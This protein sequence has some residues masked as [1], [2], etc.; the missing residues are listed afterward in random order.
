MLLR[1]FNEDVEL[2]NHH[3]N[4]NG[5]GRKDVAG[6]DGQASKGSIPAQEDAEETQRRIQNAPDEGDE[7]AL[8]A[9]EDDGGVPVGAHSPL[10]PEFEQLDA[11]GA[12]QT[13][14]AE[15]DHERALEAELFEDEDKKVRD[16]MPE[17]EGEGD[18]VNTT[19]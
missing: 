19:V 3:D 11:L 8:P 12:E 18:E 4:R 16:A 14:L 13:A 10:N 15:E 2:V 9:S 1:I 5:S 17:R 7:I 6:K